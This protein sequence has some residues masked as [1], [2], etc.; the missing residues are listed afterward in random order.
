[1]APCSSAGP[2]AAALAGSRQRAVAAAANA[3]TN[4][5][6]PGAI[7]TGGARCAMPDAGGRHQRAGPGRH[8]LA[9]RVHQYQLVRSVGGGGRRPWRDGAHGGGRACHRALAAAVRLAAVAHHWHHAVASGSAAGAGD[10]AP[11]RH[12]AGGGGARAGGGGQRTVCLDESGI[13]KA[14]QFVER[15]H[16]RMLVYLALVGTGVVLL[17]GPE[18]VGIGHACRPAAIVPHHE[19]QPPRAIF[20]HRIGIGYIAGFGQRYWLGFTRHGGGLAVGLDLRAVAAVVGG[21]IDV[22]ADDIDHVVTGIPRCV[23]AVPHPDQVVQ[24]VHAHQPVVHMTP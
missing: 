15:D 10:A 22:V 7:A 21:V 3:G 13:L 9:H 16:I 5:A 24:A 1:M 2:V 18:V 17:A 11:A 14:R 20:R 8:R 19:P 6:G 23:L 4:A 12:R